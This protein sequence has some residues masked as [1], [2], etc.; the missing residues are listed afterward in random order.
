MNKQ[1]L[2]GCQAKHDKLTKELFFHPADC[3]LDGIVLSC[4]ESILLKPNGNIHGSPDNLLFDPVKKVLYQVEYKVRGNESHAKAQLRRDSILL[5]QLFP[6]YTV[7]SIYMDGTG[8]VKYYN[9]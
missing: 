7:R 4:R 1:K 9:R 2:Q 6:D 5:K 8:A 3:G